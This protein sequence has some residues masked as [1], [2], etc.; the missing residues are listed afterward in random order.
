ML[1]VC[2]EFAGRSVCSSSG[3]GGRHIPCGGVHDGDRCVRRGRTQ[4]RPTNPAKSGRLDE[5]RRTPADNDRGT[6][7][8]HADRIASPFADCNGGDAFPH[9]SLKRNAIRRSSIRPPRRCQRTAG[10]ETPPAARPNPPREIRRYAACDND[11][12]HDGVV[13][14]PPPP[15][16]CSAAG[17]YTAST[18]LRAAAV[19]HRAATGH[20]RITARSPTEP[21]RRHHEVSPP[22]HPPPAGR[23]MGRGSAVSRGCSSGSKACSGTLGTN[24]IKVAAD[25]SAFPYLS[26]PHLF[27]CQTRRR[28]RLILGFPN[29]H[30]LL[31]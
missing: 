22:A 29:S 12:P 28:R 15:H 9:R 19:R 4:S 7:D 21:P 24:R 17:C 5:V 14:F 27:D 20:S 1:R 26:R 31:I 25:T 30:P 13:T 6:G 23:R 10:P 16:G 3:G 2:C 8:R 11:I 18:L